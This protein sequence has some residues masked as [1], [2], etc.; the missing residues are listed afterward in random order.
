[1]TALVP[2]YFD[3]CAWNHLFDRKVNLAE[4]LPASAYQLCITREVEIELQPLRANESKSDLVDFVD[5]AILANDVQTTSTFG[6]ASVEA[7]GSLSE[8]QVFGGFDVGTWR[9]D[10]DRSWL[11]QEKVLRMLPKS[12]DRKKQLGKNQADASMAVRAF[13]AVVLTAESRTKKGPCSWHGAKAVTWYSSRTLKP[14][15]LP[16]MSSYWAER[17]SPAHQRAERVPPIA[18]SAVSGKR[19]PCRTR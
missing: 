19:F 1:M 15:A 18:R 16:C 13:N 12:V 17:H 7:D 10:E 5:S 3:S 9:S 2:V 6:F 14:V 8:V 4:E 11:S